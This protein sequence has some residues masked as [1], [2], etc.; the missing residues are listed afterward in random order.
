MEYL[1]DNSFVDNGDYEKE[2]EEFLAKFK[3]DLHEAKDT[4]ERLYQES[5]DAF[6]ALFKKE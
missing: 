6:R 2:S 3:T 4:L 1:R 5:E